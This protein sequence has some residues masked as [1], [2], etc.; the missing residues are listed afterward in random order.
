MEVNIRPWARECLQAV[1]QWYQ[2]VTFTAG[3]QK[4]AD[5][6]LD[7]FDPSGQLIEKRFYRHHCYNTSDGMHIKDLRIFE[8]C[9]NLK[10]VILIDNAVFSYAFQISNGVPMMPFYSDKDDIEMIHLTKYLERLSHFD[11]IRPQISAT[12]QIEEMKNP[13]L[14]EI[15][16][17]IVEYRTEEMSEEDLKM[18]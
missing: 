4:Y 2:V 14:V 17:G 18:L 5:N 11:D 15:V 7:E 9:Y 13:K 10:D 1:S 16:E 6:I 12:F 8:K 3:S